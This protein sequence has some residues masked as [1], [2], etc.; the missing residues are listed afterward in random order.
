MNDAAVNVMRSAGFDWFGINPNQKSVPIDDADWL[1]VNNGE[2]S[3]I[4]AAR[5]NT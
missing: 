1:K 3:M 2:S 4:T 5:Q